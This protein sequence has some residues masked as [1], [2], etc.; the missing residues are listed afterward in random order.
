MFFCL[1]KID[2]NGCAISP[3]DSAPVATWY[4]NGWNRW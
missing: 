2:R 3:G 4:S 1:R